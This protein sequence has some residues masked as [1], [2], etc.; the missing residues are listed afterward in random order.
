MNSNNTVNLAGRIPDTEKLP[1]K[2]YPGKD[3]EKSSGIF[4]GM[5]SV[6]RA[7]K[8]KD[9]EYYPEDLIPFVAF[10]VKAK[11]IND[12]INRG[13]N[14]TM[15]GEIRREDDYED[16]DGNL[17]S[18]GLALYVDDVHGFGNAKKTTKKTDDGDADEAEETPAPS[19]RSGLAGRRR[20]SA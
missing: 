11:Y 10:G 1:F 13:D 6:R 15:C 5:I 18:G 17:K 4:R 20:R 9:D 14:V 19:R 2:Y 16:K 12:Y 8:K 3:D 7:Y